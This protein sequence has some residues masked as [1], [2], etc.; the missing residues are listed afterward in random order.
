MQEDSDRDYA[1]EA[2]VPTSPASAPMSVDE[3][4]NLEPAMKD[5]LERVLNLPGADEESAGFLLMVNA[6][7]MKLVRSLGAARNAPVVSVRSSR[8]TWC[9]KSI[10]GRKPRTRSSCCQA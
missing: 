7:I 10:A 9:Q 4:K 1:D 8:D 2:H 5:D 3:V 6:E